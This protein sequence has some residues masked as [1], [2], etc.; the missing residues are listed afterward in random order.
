MIGMRAPQRLPGARASS[1]LRKS[2]ILRGP[3]G[4]KNMATDPYAAPKAP[5]ADTPGAPIEGNFVPD[6]QSVPA[7]NGWSWIVSGWGLFKQQ[8]GMWILVVIIMIALMVVLGI[9]PLVNLL[10]A[11]IGPVFV[12]GLMIGCRAIDE[13]GALEIGH[14][15]AGF[16]E[17][18]G[19]LILVGLFN[20]GAWLLVMLV[21][22]L[23]VGG[24]A[25]ALRT[26]GAD[27]AASA[28]SAAL[29]G[30]IGLALGLPIYM[31]IWF[32]PALITLNGMDVGAALKASF[33]GCLKN[34][35]SFLVY[36]IVGFVLAVVA[37]IP[38]MLGWL[39][40]GPVLIASVYTG[41]RDIFY[42]Q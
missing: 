34:I 22:F 27:H 32:A 18:T 6:G 24:S 28:A 13:G 33:F 39:V 36:G 9:I 15:F 40:L 19:K 31:A 29:A 12:G 20:I 35:M 25:F 7:G 26:A 16:R 1:T 3:K 21:I 4:E 41:Y 37:S 10:V 30:L 11:L 23:L 17:H 5:V 14:I 38:V 8:P 2:R 42:A